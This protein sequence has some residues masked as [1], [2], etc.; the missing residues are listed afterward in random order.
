MD[1]WGYKKETNSIGK[2]CFDTAFRQAR[3]AVFRL[4]NSKK[5]PSTGGKE[6]KNSQS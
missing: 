1:L 3:R 5:Q 2:K 6:K 4:L